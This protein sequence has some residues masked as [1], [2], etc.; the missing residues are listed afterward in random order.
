M[1]HTRGGT[2]AEGRGTGFYSTLFTFFSRRREAAA[3]VRGG[4]VA[5]LPVVEIIVGVGA[6]AR[7]VRTPAAG[8][9]GEAAAFGS[10]CARARA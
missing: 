3:G 7:R 4:T 6:C 1:N 9:C 5:E 2:L 8:G 10:Y